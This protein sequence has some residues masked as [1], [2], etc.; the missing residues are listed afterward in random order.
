MKEVYDR[1]LVLILEVGKYELYMMWGKDNYLK[2]HNR[3][4]K[5]SKSS[6]EKG[7]VCLWPYTSTLHAPK[8]CSYLGKRLLNKGLSRSKFT[9]G[10]MSRKNG[11]EVDISVMIG[12]HGL[13]RL[14]LLLCTLE[15]IS[16]QTGVQ[17]ECIV[18]EQDSKV[19]IE[20][21]LPPWVR[22]CFQYSDVKAKGYNRSA[23]F[24]YGEKYARGKI[25]ILHDNDILVPETYCR[26]I[27]DLVSSGWEAINPKRFVYYLDKDH[28]EQVLYN[29]AEIY[30][31]KP[32]YIV[33]NLEAGG[34]M[35]ITKRGYR[36]IGGMDEKF[37][38]WG[39]EDNEFWRRCATLRRWI[40]GYEPVIHLW[41]KGQPLKNTEDNKNI[42]L[43][44][45]LM[46]TSVDERIKTLAAQNGYSHAKNH[47]F[48]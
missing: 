3:Y 12:H 33:Q 45:E 17:L 13:E 4:E 32:A 44:K 34:S 48:G 19:Q 37:V 20:R 7:Y 42:L 10:K 6:N 39:G 22:Y 40:W 46:D 21:H 35:A 27:L 26:S 11:S 36:Y 31:Q 47:D 29:F 15:Y 41:H 16:G 14:P 18:I 30:K 24:N 25:L 28:S 5:V 38:G 23:A 2:I 1:L 8:K 43:A 9:A